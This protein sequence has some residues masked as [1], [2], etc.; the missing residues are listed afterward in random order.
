M[1]G[2]LRSTPRKPP[3]TVLDHAS[4]LASPS[5]VRETTPPAP[6]LE[7]AILGQITDALIA[8][9]TDWRYTYVNAAAAQAFGL[10]PATLIGQR[11][12]DVFPQAEGSDFHRD[13]LRA[14]REQRLV[15][16]EE[17]FP[18]WNR[19]YAH[20][21]FP[22]PGGIAILTRDVTESKALE[23]ERRRSEQRF[24]SLVTATAQIVWRYLPGALAPEDNDDWRAFTGQTS[25]QVA[26]GG[27]VASIH[28]DD[29][30]RVIDTW[31]SALAADQIYSV[32]FRLRR[33]DGE[34]RDV[35]DRAVALR[36]TS[37]QIQE[38]VGITID[39]TDQR[40]AERTLQELSTLQ[41]AILDSAEHSI[42]TAGTDGLVRT[43]NPAAERLLGYSAE[44]VIGKMSAEH[45][46]DPLEIAARAQDLT[47][48]VGRPVLPGFEMFAI[49]TRRGVAHEREWTYIR[50]DGV[51]IPVSLSVTALRDSSGAVTGSLGIA[52][53]ITERKAWEAE[54]ERLLTDA[55]HRADRDPLTG[56]FNHAVFHQKLAEEAARAYANK[57]PLAVAML[58]MDNFKFFNTVYGHLA[59]DQVLRQVA[60]TLRETSRASDVLARFGGDEFALLL[61]GTGRVDANE[62]AATLQ[63]R[64]AR[65]VFQPT[66]DDPAVPLSLSIGV[67]VIP[68][69][70]GTH[71]D[72]VRLADDR[73]RASKTGRWG[74]VSEAARLTS[75]LRE[76]RDGFSLLDD[77]VTAVDNKDR[78]TRRHCH[79]VL[80]HAL[81]LARHIELSPAEEEALTIA[82]LLHDL[83][84]VGVPD[85]V[86]RKPGPLTDHEWTLMRRH[87]LMG[88]AIVASVP[89]FDD[90]LDAIRFHHERPDGAGYPDGLRRDAIPHLAR[91][92]AVADGYSAL[93]SDRPYR[94]ALPHD[95]ACALLQQNAG[96]RWDAPLVA[97]FLD[98]CDQ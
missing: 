78:Y 72:A 69:E 43:F 1:G 96:T 23:D 67:A 58:D 5:L 83:G 44:E 40:R 87:P 81:R 41:R 90:A 85:S 34:Y 74:E 14:A 9:D 52:R 12:W 11:L 60:Q 66:P 35:W 25:E 82:A 30:Q 64:M 62:L 61:P 27:W 47:R 92:L 57:R 18:A 73:L 59:G 19:W 56:L 8:V 45:W 68:E 89:G 54:R 95:D 63:A 75:L 26:S 93:T 98:T 79:D 15:E 39:M 97:A 22:S 55:L 20:R 50:K 28:P 17:Y 76:T 2:S 37:G 10:D 31:Q 16:G 13:C 36:D 91:I 80:T 48:A 29:R 38:W 88:A 71:L 51:R 42:I 86:L 21:V 49:T 6:S 7:A 46:H 77:L 53:N 3:H 65:S 70:A 33:H 84:K 94:A 4:R 32:Q 24:R